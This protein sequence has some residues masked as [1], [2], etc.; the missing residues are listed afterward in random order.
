MLERRASR[1]MLSVG[2]PLY[3]TFPCVR[4]H[5][6]RARVSELY[7]K[8]QYPKRIHRGADEFYLATTSPT[9]WYDEKQE[10]EGSHVASGG[11][12]LTDT[13]AFSGRHLE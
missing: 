6:S 10:S 4:M 11:V 2:K 5:L 7:M 9:N 13:D 8:S 1:L 3:R 12:G